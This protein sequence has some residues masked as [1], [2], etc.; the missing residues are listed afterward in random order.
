MRFKIGDL[1]RGASVFEDLPI[2]I[3]SKGDKNSDDGP[4]AYY[5]VLVGESVERRSVKW[6]ERWCE[7]LI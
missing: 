2:L 5:N 6:L 3:V 4:W 1:L 7:K